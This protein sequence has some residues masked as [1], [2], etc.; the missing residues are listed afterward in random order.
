[1]AQIVC[2]TLYPYQGTEGQPSPLIFDAGEEIFLIKK[3]NN[4][5]WEG[6]KDGQRGWFPAAYVKEK[7]YIPSTPEEEEEEPP[8]AMEPLPP[9]WRE[10]KA[11]DGRTYYFFKKTKE[12][13]WVRP[14]MRNT[15]GTNSIIRKTNGESTRRL[16]PE[17]KHSRGLSDASSQGYSPPSSPGPFSGDDE[18]EDKPI[19]YVV[20]GVCLPD[21]KRAKEQELLQPGRYSYCDY[22]WRDRGDKH[23]YESGF[24][25]LLAKAQKGK[26]ICKEMSELFKAR[27]ALELQYAKGLAALSS[28]MFAETEEGTMYDAWKQV[29]AS[30]LQESKIHRDFAGK[31]R[32]EIEKPLADYKE[33]GKKESKK[34]DANMAE[35]RKQM[36]HKYLVVERQ[37]MSMT[38]RQRELEAKMSSPK[39]EE[40]IE[41]AKRKSTKQREDLIH[42]VSIY[43]DAKDK[44]FEETVTQTLVLENKETQRIELVKKQINK[45]VKL[46]NGISSKT[47]KA[48]ASVSSKVESVDPDKDRELWVKKNKTGSVRPIDMVSP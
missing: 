37:K 46:V 44:W 33:E 26:H 5:W 43:N 40:D 20:N 10:A 42:A 36:T 22:F 31:L 35:L 30:L 28:E 29:K 1:M 19:C 9:G 38:E 47:D 13:T 11:P 15:A 21:A 3:D 16:R 25:I 14:T 41:K 39:R 24:S 18:E 32:T 23:V 48:C 12:T 2:E 45:Y 27:E 6:E 7:E 34:L 8:P 17:Q 4:G